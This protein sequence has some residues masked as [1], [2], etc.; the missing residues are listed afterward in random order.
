[1]YMYVSP[2][3][4]P[5][6]LVGIW[7]KKKKKELG[8]FAHVYSYYR[9]KRRRSDFKAAGMQ[10]VTV[11]KYL[12]CEGCVYLLTLLILA[13]PNKATILF[14]LINFDIHKL[15]R[16]IKKKKI[17]LFFKSFVFIMIFSPFFPISFYKIISI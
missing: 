7:L 3:P 16:T 17:C 10:T 15:A 13:N 9:L 5:P 12:N 11:P 14:K 2:I 4:P 6:Y 8:Y 1:M